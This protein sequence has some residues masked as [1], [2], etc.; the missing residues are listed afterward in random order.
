MRTGL[1]AILAMLVVVF[2]GGAVA[3]EPVGR[4]LKAIPSISASG[5]T[6]QSGDEVFFL[7][8]IAADANGSGEFEFSDGT[9]LAVARRSVVVVDQ[10][11]L[12]DRTRFQK[13]GLSVAKGT[14][15][16]IS[17]SSDHSAY[18]L[19][20]PMGTMGVRGTAFDVSIRDGRTYVVLLNGRARFCAGGNCQT[21]ASSG[22]YVS[23]N[24]RTVS[25]PVRVTRAF[26]SRK[27]AAKVF[28]FL[29]NPSL[30]SPRFRVRGSDLFLVLTSTEGGWNV[31][32]SFGGPAQSGGGSAGGGGQG[33]AGGNGG[34]CN[35]NCGNGVGNGGIG[36]GTGNE[37]HHH[38]G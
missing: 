2:A 8:R 1:S 33:G 38:G 12:K 20:T 29:A 35:T 36:N 4:T 14:F 24:G 31:G 28:P 19:R 30:L 23:S 16:W 22:D 27:D 21:L 18:R 26:K 34:N 25:A 5:R 9:K 6:L 3:G 17:G 7:D 37:G 32:N 11:V 15:R 10:F 13:F